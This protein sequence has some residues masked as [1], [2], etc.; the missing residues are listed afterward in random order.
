MTQ[1]IQRVTATLLMQYWDI[2]GER[3]LVKVIILHLLRLSDKPK[4]LNQ[5]E[6]RSRSN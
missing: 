5:L 6:N 1:T 4:V 2:M 3:D